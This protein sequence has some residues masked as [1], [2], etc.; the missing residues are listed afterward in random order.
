MNTATLATE[1]GLA[2]IAGSDTTSVAL[3]NMIFYLIQHPHHFA[4]LRAEVD[5]AAGEDSTVYDVDVDSDQLV[6]LK[7]LQAVINETIRLQPA[8]PNGVQRTPPKEGG[9]V[10]VAGQ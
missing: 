7:F 10:V 8:V 6:G 3:S 9:P 5:A 1:A 2:I 4:R